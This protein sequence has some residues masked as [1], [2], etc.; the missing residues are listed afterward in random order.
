MEIVVS[1]GHLFEAEGDLWPSAA[2]QI[3]SIIGI[4]DIGHSEKVVR[5]ETNIL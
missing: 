5:L 1:G 4:A 3:L 2:R